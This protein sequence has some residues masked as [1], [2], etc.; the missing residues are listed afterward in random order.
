MTAD[1]VCSVIRRGFKDLQGFH[2]YKYLDIKKDRL[3]MSTKKELDGNEVI[4]RRGALYICEKWNTAV[5]EI[6]QYST[7]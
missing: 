4:C 6:V 5:A 3:E 1:E 7:G 2:D